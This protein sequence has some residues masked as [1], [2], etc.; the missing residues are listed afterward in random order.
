MS[1]C[2]ICRKTAYGID[3]YR[4]PEGYVCERCYS[5]YKREQSNFI[6]LCYEK[7]KEEMKKFRKEYENR[8]I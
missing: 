1:G 5:D 8:N 2:I 3:T 6:F 4:T 7:H